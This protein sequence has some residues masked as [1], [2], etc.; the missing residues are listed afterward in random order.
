MGKAKTYDRSAKTASRRTMMAAPVF[1][2]GFFTGILFGSVIGAVTSLLLDPMSGGRRR[3][4][5]RDKAIRYKNQL[6]LYGRHHAK[7]VV[8]RV[9]GLV[10]KAGQLR[11]P[12]EPCAD[13][14]LVSRVRSDC[15][16]KLSHPRSVKVE[17]KD[18]VVTLSGPILASEI[19]SVVRA[20]RR[21]RGVKSVINNLMAHSTPAHIPGLQGD[22]KEYLRRH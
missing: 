15:G 6:G 13:E 7:D 22:G 10:Y 9:H 14:T 16:R 4:L 18:G 17:A 20:V 2:T 5:V 1:G 19:E 3:S 12:L 8:N 11:K 21:V